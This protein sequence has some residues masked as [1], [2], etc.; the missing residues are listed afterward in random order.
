[1]SIILKPDSS[2]TDPQ[3]ITVAA[4]VAVCKAIES[5]TEK[6]PQ[7]KWVNDI[8][9]EGKKIC[10]ILSEAVTDFESGS[11]ESIVVGIGVDCSISK[12]ML[13]DELHGIVGSL[14]VEELSRN[15][16]A[17]EIAAGVLDSLGKL[18]DVELID[19]YRKRSLMYGKEIRFLYDGGMTFADVT[20][21][22]DMGNLLVRLKTGE[23]L[24]LNSGEVSI[25]NNFQ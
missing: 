6:Q 11:I 25:G 16:L 23:N 21:I 2:V 24:V 4:A 13:P 5:L 9:L 7:I 10:G 22:N 20:G 19:E 14:G 12:E 3:M 1:M 15:R 18:G 8:Y 17:A